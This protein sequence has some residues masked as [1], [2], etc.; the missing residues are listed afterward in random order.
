MAASAILLE[1]KI[2]EK[3]KEHETHLAACEADWKKT[4]KTHCSAV[5]GKATDLM[6][7]LHGAVNTRLDT[8][9]SRL[10]AAEGSIKN[11]SY[12]KSMYWPCSDQMKRDGVSGQTL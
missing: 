9:Q 6:A 2:N 10:K 7:D 4:G 11:I 8:L 1:T 3:A 12:V 5:S